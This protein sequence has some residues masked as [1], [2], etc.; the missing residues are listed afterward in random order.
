MTIT[1]SAATKT[2]IN[3]VASK[4][5]SVMYKVL[6]TLSLFWSARTIAVVGLGLLV[7][8]GEVAMSVI[9]LIVVICRLVT[10]IVLFAVDVVENLKIIEDDAIRVDIFVSG[11]IVVAE[12]NFFISYGSRTKTM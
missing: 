8:F 1:V 6:F 12:I 9:L 11:F 10:V 7:F 3:K 4:A 2:I 5:I